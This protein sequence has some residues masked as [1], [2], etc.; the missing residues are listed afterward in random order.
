MIGFGFQTYFESPTD[1]Y[2]WIIRVDGWHFCLKL[3]RWRIEFWLTFPR[4][5]YSKKYQEFM[6]NDYR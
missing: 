4:E 6:K 5:D 3:W 1:S 2:H